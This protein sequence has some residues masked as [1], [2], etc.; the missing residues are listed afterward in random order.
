[1][2]DQKLWVPSDIRET[3]IEHRQ[4]VIRLGE[5]HYLVQW[6]WGAKVWCVINMAALDDHSENCAAF[7]FR[8]RCQ[9]LDLIGQL[10]S[11][12]RIA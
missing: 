2:T 6:Q 4:P 10:C 7:R 3:L 8:K 9:H 5:N 1:M 12:E 11:E